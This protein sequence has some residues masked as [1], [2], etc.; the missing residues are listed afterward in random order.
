MQFAEEGLIVLKY[1]EGE[2][3]SVRPTAVDKETRRS[4]MNFLNNFVENSFIPTI[5][6]DFKF[7]L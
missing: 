2:D 7:V 1:L 5:F 4:L 6:M 3:D